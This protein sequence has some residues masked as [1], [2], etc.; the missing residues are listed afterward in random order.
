MAVKEK[1][2]W[3]WLRQSWKH[4][5]GL[6]FRRVENSVSVGDPDVQGCFRGNYFELELKSV[7]R[8]VKEITDLRLGVRVEQMLY[9]E[10]RHQCSGNSWFFL[11]VGSK[12]TKA[13]RY[14][15]HGSLARIIS[16][17]IQEKVL[18]KIAVEIHKVEEVL[19][20]IAQKP[21]TNKLF[22]RQ[23]IVTIDT[24][25]KHTNL[26]TTVQPVEIKMTVLKPFESAVV[27]LRFADPTLKIQRQLV[28]KSVLQLVREPDNIYD[29]KAIAVEYQ[30]QR[31]GYLK[32]G[33]ALRLA[34]QMD[35]G[36]QAEAVICC[37][38]PT[39]AFTIPVQIQQVS[40]DWG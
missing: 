8:P 20:Y 28:N 26:Y 9:H 37:V 16:Y 22:T 40:D 31:I 15:V 6:H 29:P 1:V 35:A 36:V 2:L 21:N 10:K 33:D 18:Q 19:V 11:L 5:D 17:P 23:P 30:G 4:E 7:V 32:K 12:G 39:N 14:L 25:H 3:G 27:G 13:S 34:P 24:I 38:D